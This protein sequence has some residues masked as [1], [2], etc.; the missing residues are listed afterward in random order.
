MKRET[1]WNGCL[2]QSVCF[3]LKESAGLIAYDGDGVN[4]GCQRRV[5]LVGMTGSEAGGRSDWR[6]EVEI[7]RRKAKRRG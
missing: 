1:L 5:V 6:M 4:E 2:R 3:Q 7:E